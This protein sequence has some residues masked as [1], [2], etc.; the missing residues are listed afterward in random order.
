MNITGT[1]NQSPV[2]LYPQDVPLAEKKEKR[3]WYKSCAAACRAMGI[4][5]STFKAAKKNN[6]N[7]YDRDG[8]AWKIRNAAT[9]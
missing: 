7:V 1:D 9:E 2:Y 8:R 4:N 6:H 3:V 5:Q